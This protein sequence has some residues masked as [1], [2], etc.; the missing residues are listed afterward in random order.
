M[1]FLKLSICRYNLSLAIQSQKEKQRERLETSPPEV[2]AHLKAKQSLRCQTNY[3][4]IPVLEEYTLSN[5]HIGRVDFMFLKWQSNVTIG[6]NF[7]ISFLTIL[8][9]QEKYVSRT[10][11]FLNRVESNFLIEL[12]SK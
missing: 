4:P 2:G 11:V 3:L 10:K 5:N 8:I 7:S 9:V 1:L 12:V 6:N